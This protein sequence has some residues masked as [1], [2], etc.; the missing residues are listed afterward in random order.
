MLSW[1]EFVD[2]ASELRLKPEYVAQ[3]KPFF[4][5]LDPALYDRLSADPLAKLEEIKAAF[6]GEEYRRFLLIAAVASWPEMVR[7]YKERHFSSQQLDDIRP[8]LGLWLD[9]SMAD[10][11]GAVAG[12]DGRMFSWTCALREGR[13]LQFGRLQCNYRHE[14]VGKVACFENPDGSIRMEECAEHRDDAVFSYGDSCICLHIPAS[15]PLKRALCIDSL[16]K[17]TAFFDTTQQ[18]FEYKAVICYSWILDPVFPKIMKSTNLADFQKLGH[19]YRLEGYDETNE[20]V[21]RVFDIPGGTPADVG[22]KPWNTGM[23][24]AV[25]E[26]LRNGGRFNEYGLIILRR[27]LPALLGSE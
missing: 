4:D 14:F 21:W 10:T 7:L 1:K 20:V 19:L 3:T 8:D 25:G 18:D 17:M 24:R 27:E 12:L 16:R 13:I 2:Y 26:Y 6:P 23:R 5:A 9:K 15:G 22:K 11:D